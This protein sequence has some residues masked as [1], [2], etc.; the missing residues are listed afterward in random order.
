MIDISIDQVTNSLAGRVSLYRWRK[1]VY[2]A[3]LL[4]SLGEIWDGAHRNVIDIGGG[5]GIMAQAVKDLFP[6]EKVASIDLNDR[7][8]DRLN[9]ETS[10]YDGTTLPF[11][12]NSFDCA[13]MFNV[14]HHVRREGRTSLLKE[15]GRVA[16]T[17]YIKDHIAAT[18]LDHVRLAILDLLGNIPFGGMVRAHYLPHAEW[19]MLAQQAGF[20]IESR[21]FNRYRSG[22]MAW[23]FPNS[24]EVLMKWTVDENRT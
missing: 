19:E 11:A 3:A 17:I 1:P 14:L 23:I 10:T 4:S 9:I 13:L 8:L 24:L 2:Q 21:R 16:G 12:D 5:T 18:A 20:R 6:V 7:F 15:C 22:P